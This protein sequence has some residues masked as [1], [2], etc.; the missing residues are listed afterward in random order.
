MTATLFLGRL[1]RCPLCGGMRIQADGPHAPHFDKSRVLVD[2]IG[3]PIPRGVP[4]VP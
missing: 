4:H 3:T 1:I 2:C